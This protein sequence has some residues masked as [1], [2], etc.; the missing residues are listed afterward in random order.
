MVSLG[1]FQPLPDEVNVALGCLD[2]AFRFLLERMQHVD[3][4]A[5]A[6]RVSRA[7]G[8]SVEVLD[9]FNRTTTEPF[10]Q[11]RGNRGCCPSC[12]RNNSK[13]NESCTAGGKSR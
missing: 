8:V 9:K 12:A 11:L 7:V 13:P 5:K 4:I 1:C 3:S 6:N 10:Q 2:A